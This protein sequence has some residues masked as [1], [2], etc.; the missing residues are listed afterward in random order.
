MIDGQIWH[1]HA[2]TQALKLSQPLL[3]ACCNGHVGAAVA[4]E[5]EG[6]DVFVVHDVEG[7]A[8]E[9]NCRAELAHESVAV[10]SGE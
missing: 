4:T 8:A 7:A 5:A 3:S 1:C 9:V 2:A 6:R 10:A